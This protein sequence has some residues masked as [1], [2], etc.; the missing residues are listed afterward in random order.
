[1]FWTDWGSNPKIER[2]GMDGSSRVAIVYQDLVWPNG[3]ALDYELRRLYWT[4][5]GAKKIEFAN[6]DGSGRQVRIDA[7]YF[8]YAPK[9]HG[10]FPCNVCGASFAKL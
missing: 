1:M 10:I 5:A 8:P 4:D 6:I 3:L 2:A 9:A 7:P